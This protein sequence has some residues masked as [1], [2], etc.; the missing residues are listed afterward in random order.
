MAQPFMTLLK[1]G[2]DYLKTWPM[3]K[4]L[5][6]LFPE[7]RVIA[8]TRFA[9]KVM[10]PVSILACAVL[11]NTQGQSYLPQ[12]IAIGL[13]FMSIPVQ[14]LLW[15]GHRANQQLPPSL[16]QWYQDIHAKMRLQG[17]K[18]TAA[19]S[20]PRYMELATLLKN[21]FDD[22]DSAFTQSWFR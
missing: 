17:C 1:D 6:A 10:P 7:C 14:G 16:R 4:E 11:F 2:Q 3:K 15:L 20:R 19:R 13:F 18:V 22:M 12:I 21:A 9:M 5:Y 8:G